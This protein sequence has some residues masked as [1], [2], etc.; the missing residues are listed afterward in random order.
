MG[1]FQESIYLATGMRR[2][3]LRIRAVLG[4]VARP[5]GAVAIMAMTLASMGLGWTDWDG[6]NP[7]LAS[8]LGLAVGSGAVVYAASLMGL[9]FVMGRPAGA[10]SDALRIINRLVRY[11]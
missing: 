8:N 10:E 9:W 5:A 2:L 3:K 4:S 6:G 11:R 1:I 7:A